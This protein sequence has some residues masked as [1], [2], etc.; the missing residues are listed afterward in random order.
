M[1]AII[2]NLT[3]VFVSIVFV[4]FAEFREFIITRYYCR[5]RLLNRG[6]L[7]GRSLNSRFTET[8]TMYETKEVIH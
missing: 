8:A 4:E 1:I 7:T 3:L 6:Q 5:L 2:F